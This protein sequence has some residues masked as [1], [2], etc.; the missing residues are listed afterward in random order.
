MV[1]SVIERS[2]PEVK[3]LRLLFLMAK[4][5]VLKCKYFYK[6]FYSILLL[7][8]KTLVSIFILL[9]TFFQKRSFSF[10]QI[11]MELK[12]LIISEACYKKCH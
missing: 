10:S 8:D 1:W 3:A 6:C 4:P 11:L 9:L 12:E 5:M 2:A 7:S